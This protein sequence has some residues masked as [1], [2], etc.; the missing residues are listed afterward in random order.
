L[1]F[2][3][4][5][6]V[7]G[8][9]LIVACAAVLLLLD[10][11]HRSSA[12]VTK[13]KKWKVTIVEFN[14]VL[15]VEE[16]ER[17]VLQGLRDANL[18]EGRD[19]DLKILNAQGDMPT[20]SGLI[21]AAVSDG[22]DLLITMSTPTLQA[23]IKRAGKTP[24]VFTYVADAIAAGAAKSDTDHL[25]N[26]TGVYFQAAFDEILMIM[27]QT[28]P[29]LHTIGSLY[30]PAE[31]NMVFYKNKMEVAA[32]KAGIE[33][34]TLPVNTSSD[35][36]DATL[37]L[38]SQ[39][40]DAICQIPGNL[41]AASFPSVVSPANQARIPVFAFQT[42][43]VHGGAVMALARDY[44]DAGQETAHMAARVIRGEDPAKIPLI[45]FSKTK[46]ILNYTAAKNLNLKFPAALIKQAKETI[47]EP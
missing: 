20:V 18:Q 33:F 11:N 9:L 43:Q 47:G 25:P 44:F 2:V 4:R 30:V 15:D 21:D 7:L 32:K 16:S 45:G 24:I 42:S 22:S 28:L 38:C 17:G 5:R 6:L 39:K 3:L 35:V 26:L 1:V 19:Y 10:L 36:P 27:R 40:I 12:A 8:I 14:Q 46:I 34:V 31:T 13:Q 37:A 29:E 41:I 23:A